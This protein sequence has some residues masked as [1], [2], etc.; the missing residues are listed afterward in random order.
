[1][2]VLSPAEGH[3]TPEDLPD[4]LRFTPV[5]VKARHD[6]WSAQLQLRFIVALAR[7]ASVEE[8]ARGLGRRRQSVYEL[9]RRSGG[10]G[11]AR[12]WDSAV[13]FARQA[14]GAAASAGRVSSSVE[15]LLV[16]RHYRGRLIGYVQREDL[17]GLMG[18]L[19]RLDRLAEILEAKHGAAALRAMIERSAAARGQ[20]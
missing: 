15:T 12:A 17:S 11:F 13:D 10:E 5:P 7:G 6:G 4:F 9:R 8:A 14:R 1:M 16:P 3:L 2:P 20:R 19:G 18:R